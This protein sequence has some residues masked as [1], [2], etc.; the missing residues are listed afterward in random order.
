MVGH[1]AI[2]PFLGGM[3]HGTHVNICM[4][5]GTHVN[6]DSDESWHTCEREK[7]AAYQLR[8]NTFYMSHDAQSEYMYESWH[9]CE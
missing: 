6:S 8:E 1:S 7:E 9:I 3:S 5:H 2:A 4:S